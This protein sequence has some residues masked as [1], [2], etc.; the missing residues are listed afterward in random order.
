MQE[1]EEFYAK[2]NNNSIAEKQKMLC[3]VV[4]ST[5]EKK[6]NQGE[7]NTLFSVTQILSMGLDRERLLPQI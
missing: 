6:R 5:E 7:A 3:E 1:F 2:E 4:Y